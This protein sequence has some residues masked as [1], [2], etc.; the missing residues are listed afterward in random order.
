MIPSIFLKVNVAGSLFSELDFSDILDFLAFRRCLTIRLLS[1]TS[2]QIV[3]F[4]DN[5]EI[6]RELETRELEE[7]SH[8]LHDEHD[9]QQ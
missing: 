2:I 5:G 9:I 6:V 4:S 1:P 7:T 8:D 3:F